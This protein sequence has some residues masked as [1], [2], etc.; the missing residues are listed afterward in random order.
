[1]K[2]IA[3]ATFPLAIL[4][5]TLS[6]GSIA[7][8]QDLLFGMSTVLS[9]PAEELGHA[10]KG[11]VEAAFAEANSDGGIAGRSLRLVALDDG[12]E[13]TRTAPN[14]HALIEQQNVLAIIGNV[15]TPTAVV[16]GADRPA[17]ADPLL[18]RVHGRGDSAG[19]TSESL[20]SSTT[21]PATR[22]KRPPWWKRS[23]A[24][25]VCG[26]KR[27]RF[28]PR[29]TLT[30]MRAS[31]QAW[32]PLKD[33]GLRSESAIVHGRYERNTD[34]VEN[35]LA[36]LLAAPVAPR[37]VIMVGAYAPCARFI[38]LAREYEL[39]AILLNVSFVGAEQL[40]RAAGRM[41]EGIIITQVVPAVRSELPIVESYR[42]ALREHTEVD[43]AS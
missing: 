40:C 8:A 30:A 5:G 43:R 12:Y 19:R 32:R 10:V 7:A 14:V 21:V 41:G 26:L 39:N 38:Q 34:V 36:D 25:P 13:P 1:M 31:C 29:E 37:A 18:R 11:G 2:T 3:G 35:A 6:A 33:H 28:S 4:V 24:K 15:G 22:R 27:S 16:A 42:A 9:G 23:S 17:F 20:P